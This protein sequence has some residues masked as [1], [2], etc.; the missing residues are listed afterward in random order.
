MNFSGPSPLKLYLRRLVMVNG[1]HEFL[2]SPISTV[3]LL[4]L[5]TTSS[6]SPLV[7]AR[8]LH[9]NQTKRK[10]TW[11]ER[12]VHKNIFSVQ[13]MAISIN[14]F[15]L[16]ALREIH[17][18]SC[19]VFT[20]F[21]LLGRAIPETLV[22]NFGALLLDLL[23]D[24]HIP[25]SH[26]IFPFLLML[27]VTCAP[28]K[29]SDCVTSSNSV[30]IKP[31][32]S[33]SNWNKTEIGKTIWLVFRSCFLLQFINRGSIES[34]TL[35]SRFNRELC[36]LD[37]AYVT[38]WVIWHKKLSETLCSPSY[39]A[40]NGLLPFISKWLPFKSIGT[41]NEAEETLEV[42]ASLEVGSPKT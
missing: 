40:L 24:R 36:L 2:V 18:L 5:G 30:L 42:G 37:G 32:C 26:V 35:Q 20:S 13:P 39:T 27:R 23:S 14:I 10:E 3:L 6:L 25:P 4:V 9:R 1:D 12:Q 16:V 31:V 34:G 19:S 17:G 29:L 38:W 33:N 7:L 41:D 22:Y 11:V 15:G 28:S 21:Y 8:K